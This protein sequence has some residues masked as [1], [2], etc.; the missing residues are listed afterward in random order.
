MYLFIYPFIL[1]H[2]EIATHFFLLEKF[3]QAFNQN[4]YVHISTLQMYH[5]FMNFDGSMEPCFKFL[6]KLWHES[7]FYG[8]W[9][10]KNVFHFA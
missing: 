8:L 2:F 1:S 9:S 5:V 4:I 7:R 3:D 10:L 6:A